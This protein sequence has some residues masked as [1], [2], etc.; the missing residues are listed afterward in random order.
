MCYHLPVR[1]VVD[2]SVFV[3]AVA[4]PDGASR[5][6]LRRCLAGELEPVMG[7]ALRA[8]YESVLTRSRRALRH[9]P[10]HPPAGG[11]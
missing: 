3:A 1:V 4:S 8:E 10:C 9:S 11:V 5:E 6:V 2:T 7:Q